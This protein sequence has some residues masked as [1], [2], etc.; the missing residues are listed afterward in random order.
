MGAAPWTRA[1]L[2]ALCAVSLAAVA[3]LASIGRNDFVRWDDDQTIRLNPQLNPPTRHTLAHVWTREHMNLWVPVTYTAWSGLAWLSRAVGGDPYAPLNPAVFHGASLALHAL[4]AG[5]VFLL[6][7]RL[8]ASDIP[9]AIGAALFAV[10]PVQ[11]EPVAWASG[12]KDVLCGLMTW[13]AVWQY[14]TAAQVDESNPRRRRLHLAFASVAFVLGLLSKPTAMVAPLLALTIEVIILARPWRGALALLW[15]ALVLSL[16]CATWTALIQPASNNAAVPLYLRPLVAADA[17]AFYLYKLVW[18]ARLGLDYGRNPA[19]IVARGWVAYTWALPLCAALA[20]ALWGRR[21]PLL[22]GGAVVFAIGVSPVLGLLR[23]D[24]QDMSTVADHYLYLSMAG[25]AMAAAEVTRRVRPAHALA[26]S[27]P[28]VL[29]LGAM[30]WR[31]AHVWKDSVA[32]F[33][34]AIVAN[35]DSYAAHNNLASAYLDRREPALAEQ[36]ARE[37]IRIR[38][39]YARAMVTLGAALAAQRRDDEAADAYRNAIVTQPTNV[40]A[41]ANLGALLARAGQSEQAI[42]HLRR[43]LELHPD[44]GAAHLTLGSLLSSTDPDRAM[45]HLRQALRLRPRD[46]RVR[47]KYGRALLQ[48][49]QPHEA[50]AEFELAMK[51]D[52]DAL[53]ALYGADDA[54]EML[55]QRGRVTDAAR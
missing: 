28:L 16:A 45:Y 18:P 43:A 6:L 31:Q 46:A 20:I 40:R 19:A 24:Y 5:V 13:T 34:H 15:P 38:P 22:V 25:V 52:P 29:V 26:L 1:S 7:R 51:L 4:T 3:C 14:V 30:S 27:A 32:L 55:K 39:N 49:G 21:R 53:D 12:L 36:H 33:T 47:T 11:V 35:P 2:L 10:H 42:S 44:D 17:L 54:R 37:A 41:H 9:T 50:L 48:R 23:F 8:G